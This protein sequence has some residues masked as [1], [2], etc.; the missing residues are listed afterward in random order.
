MIVR[1]IGGDMF[2]R[3]IAAAVFCAGAAVSVH[4]QWV[5]HPSPGIPRT[6]DGK[7]D[8]TAPA[9][10]AN[11]KPDLSGIW[12]T[13][14]TPA[15]EM[16]RLFPGIDASAVPGDNP[17]M[18]TK[19]FLNIF[20]DFKNEDVPFRPEAAQ[21]FG[22]HMQNT[23]ADEAPTARCLP[24]GIPMGDL[25]PLPRRVIH[26]PGLL[27]ILY[28]GINPH[29]M[30]YLDGRKLP[31]NPQPAWLGYSVGRWDGDVL[32]VES[33]GYTSRS[34]LDGIGHARSEKTRITER[35]RRRDLGHLEV[36]VTIDDSG[37]YTR[38]F[39]IR[40]TQTLVPDTDILEYICTENER[41]RV[42]L[43]GQK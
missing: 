25:L 28:E 9:P 22:R 35:I 13:D 7:P 11:G 12:S 38:P 15:A 36:D 34:W 32:V 30:I 42:H 14:P 19:Y 31:E 3:V 20:A 37:T 6:K 2:R 1:A 4:A 29:R 41:D 24:A 17:R 27:A 21:A 33:N 18:F 10:R 16:D 26:S 43:A 8:L 39:S 23:T 40:Y 5:T